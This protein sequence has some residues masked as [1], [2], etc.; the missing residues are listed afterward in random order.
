MCPQT[1][2]CAS[3]LLIV[4][5]LTRSIRYIVQSSN[6]ILAGGRPALNDCHS[7]ERS[8]EES[9]SWVRRFLRWGSFAFAQDDSIN[10]VFAQML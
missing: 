6:Y 3:F 1:N 8:D 4:L 10:L 5:S 9:P 7:E 2:P